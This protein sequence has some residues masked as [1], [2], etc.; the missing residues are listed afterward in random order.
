MI[1]AIRERFYCPESKGL[2]R[3]VSCAYEGTSYFFELTS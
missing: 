1:Y 3:I 2:L